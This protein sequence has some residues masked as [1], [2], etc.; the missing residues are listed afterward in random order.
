[1]KIALCCH[2]PL[3]SKLGGAKVYIEAAESYHRNGAAVSLIDVRDWASKAATSW[4]EQEKLSQLPDM[5][6]QYI[7]SQGKNFDIIEF[8]IPYLGKFDDNQQDSALLSAR[9]V[10]LPHHLLDIKIPPAPGLRSFLAKLLKGAKRKQQLQRIISQSN[11]SIHSSHFV[12]VP[13][14]DD[15]NKLISCGIDEKKIIVSPYGLLPERMQLLANSGKDQ[16]KKNTQPVIAF[17]GTFDWRKGAREFPEILR[18]LLKAS[19]NLKL[20]LLGTSALFPTKESV[21]NYFGSDLSQSLIVI[22]Q[23]TPDELPILL[24]ECHLGIFPSYLESFGFGVL[25]MLAAG[26]PTMGYKV[27]G[28]SSLLPP[29]WLVGPGNHI[30]LVNLIKQ[31]LESNK[32]EALSLKAKSIAQRISWIENAKIALTHY[33][34]FLNKQQTGQ[35]K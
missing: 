4:S 25:E 10:L 29:E 17:V 12:N 27:P 5:L 16:N 21:L 31:I 19:P 26:L 14:I 32:L 3:D 18:L 28:V 13:N 6:K 9:S 35:V 30:A 1:M 24:A 8:E 11:L 20:K 22:P 15:K 23:F 2:L 7:K 34:L 33:E